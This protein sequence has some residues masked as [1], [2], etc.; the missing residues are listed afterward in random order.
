MQL[1]EFAKYINPSTLDVV[2]V[3]GKEYRVYKYE[4]KVS[5]IENALV[6]ICYEVD[7]ESFKKPVYLMLKL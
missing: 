4:G 7:G 5:K 2:T 3:K 1:K 6:L